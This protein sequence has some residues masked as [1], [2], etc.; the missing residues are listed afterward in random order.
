MGASQGSEAVTR[1]L[2]LGLILGFSVLL[3]VG[4][5]IS[6]HL[7]QAHG[8]RVAIVEPDEATDV[9]ARDPLPPAPEVLAD[10]AEPQAAP[11]ADPTLMGPTDEPLA[12]SPLP[13]PDAGPMPVVIN[14]SAPRD[15]LAAA[16]E[17]QLKQRG[18]Q[19]VTTNTGDTLILPPGTP[20]PDAPRTVEQPP[21]PR[22]ST[23]AT[24]TTGSA[25]HTV[26]KGESL[27][28]IAK[29]HYG[30]GHKWRLIAD[31]NPGRVGANGNVREGVRLTI[32]GAKKF[33]DKAAPKP[34]PAP[35]IAKGAPRPAARLA[36][37]T[38]KRGDTL[39]EIS[40]RV[41][42]TSRRWPEIVT[43]NSDQIDDADD[44][45]AGMVLK[46]PAG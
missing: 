12:A 35:R 3:L 26:K 17:E 22:E 19:I 45:R 16:L 46:V 24:E 15:S 29:Q 44:I 2:K 5:L 39:G 33:P 18:A 21:A 43:L 6:D 9:Q 13:S 4:V 1:E 27:F 7:S 40:Q 31:A 30:D 32:P 20:A 8:D 41:L 42:G 14:Q 23:I 38:V 36:S 11:I 25:W 10:I 34:P 28:A 37:Y